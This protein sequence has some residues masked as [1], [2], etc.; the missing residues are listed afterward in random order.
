MFFSIEIYSKYR[1]FLF[2]L[3]TQNIFIYIYN[4]WIEANLNKSVI[5]LSL[6]DIIFNAIL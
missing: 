3:R 6:C 4:R 5:D 2:A 1:F